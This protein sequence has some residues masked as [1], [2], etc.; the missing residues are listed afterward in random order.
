MGGN[1]EVAGDHMMFTRPTSV[2]LP[3]HLVVLASC[4]RLLGVRG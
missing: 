3:R 4:W 2:G 1:S